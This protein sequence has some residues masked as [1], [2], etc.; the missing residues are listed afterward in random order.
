[1]RSLLKV[2]YFQEP[3]ATTLLE[4]AFLTLGFF[5]LETLYEGEK[6]AFMSFLLWTV[7]QLIVT[8][9]FYFLGAI[10]TYCY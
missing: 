1:M 6:R 4:F 2:Y 8:D 3:A 5:L 10:G 7:D 9:L